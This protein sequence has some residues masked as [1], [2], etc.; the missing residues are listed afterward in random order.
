M[1]KY[2]TDILVVGGGSAGVAAAVA[3]V[4]ECKVILIEQLQYL[5][6][7]ATAAEVG[8]VC[9]LYKFSKSPHS[10]FVVNG[11]AKE[12]AQELSARSHTQ[13]ISNNLGLHFLPYSIEAY[14]NVCSEFLAGNNVAVFLATRLQSVKSAGN[15]QSVIAVHNGETIQINLKAIVDCTG[16]SCVSELAGLPQIRS[17]NYQS[18]SQVFTMTGIETMS[19]GNLNLLL[20]RELKKATNDNL[21]EKA[22]ERVY[23]VPG[24]FKND[25]ASFKLSV[26]GAVTYKENNVSILR[27]GAV[28]R[29]TILINYLQRNVNAFKNSILQSIAPELGVRVGKRP[30]G[31]YCLTEED[32]LSCKKFE[33]GIANG[34]WPIEEWG[35]ALKVTMRYFKEGDYYQIP[36]DCLKSEYSPNLF[37]AGRMISATDAAIA[38][39]RV[40]GT[41]LQT[42]YAAGKLAAAY[43]LKYPEALTIR[44]IRQKQFF[45]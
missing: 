33:N 30:V 4:G 22:Y 11:F 1:K 36:A 27:N 24:S 41:C 20:M 38:S 5:G 17:E 21:L 6:G 29:I 34:A 10:E 14:K 26:P 44:A 23:L 7:K 18:A 43:C 40:M 12:F 39:A 37:F 2:N 16:D 8:T 35:D 3:A 25:S 31:K 42:G 19:E 28:K 45:T 9:G 32:V 15:I 13:T